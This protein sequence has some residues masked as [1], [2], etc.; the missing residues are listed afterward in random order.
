[1][2]SELISLILC[3]GL[4]VASFLGLSSKRVSASLIFLFYSSVF[5]GMIFT[6]FGDS[7]LGLLHMV[8]YAG[9]LSVMLLSVILMTGQSDLS[10]HSKNLS[11]IVGV[12]TIA[13]AAFAA[14]FIFTHSAGNSQIFSQDISLQLLSFMWQFRPWDLLIIVMVFMS[15]MLVLA[16]LF[17]RGE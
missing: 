8:T 4:I 17:S 10:M 11:K 16:N 9:A 1:M 15:S 12:I 2:Y 5:L 13:V 3:V 14:L 6:V 7:L